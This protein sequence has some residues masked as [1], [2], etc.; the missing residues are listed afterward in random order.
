M[1]AREL[2]REP[3]YSLEHL[4]KVHLSKERKT[5]DPEFYPK[6]FDQCESL[7]E[8]VESTAYD[9]YLT[10]ELLAKLQI[11]QLTKELTSIAGNL[12]IKS[13]QVYINLYSINF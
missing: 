3:D 13:L 9:A 10:M 2:V 6:A 5:W 4:S 7:F 1:S 8:F 12:W 11:L